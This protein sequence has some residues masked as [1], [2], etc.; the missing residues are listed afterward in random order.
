MIREKT[1]K[2]QSW[3]GRLG[4]VL[5]ACSALT[6]TIAIVSAVMLFININ[7]E[8]S[9]FTAFA[10]V[11]TMIFGALLS[12]IL[13]HTIRTPR[14]RDDD[15]N[16]LVAGAIMPFLGTAICASMHIVFGIGGYGIL[17][18]VYYAQS[19]LIVVMCLIALKK[20]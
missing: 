16:Q 13:G 11:A 17:P 10:F 14:M 2:E 15:K 8:N 19:I 18:I 6:G 1:K 20:V 12:V 3:R 4:V 5:F 9:I 7:S